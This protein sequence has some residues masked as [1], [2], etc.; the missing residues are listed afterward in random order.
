[1]LISEIPLIMTHKKHDWPRIE[2]VYVT[3]SFSQLSPSVATGK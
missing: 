3:S 1:V 2:D